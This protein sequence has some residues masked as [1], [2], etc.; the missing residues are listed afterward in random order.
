MG[1]LNDGQL[2]LN[3]RLD[4]LPQPVSELVGSA[5]GGVTG[6]ILGGSA[7]TATGGPTAGAPAPSRK[8]D[9]K[10]ERQQANNWCWAAVTVSVADF[11]EKP[12]SHKQ[13]TRANFHFGQTGCCANPDST[14]CDKPFDP[15]VSLSAVGHFKSSQNSSLTFDQVKEQ[16]N[17]M[18]PIVCF[19]DWGTSV[20][21][22]VVIDGYA[23]SSTGTRYLY[24][25]DPGDGAS[26]AYVEN[27]FKTKYA[28][29]GDWTFTWLTK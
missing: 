2:P 5:L 10:C 6:G 17:A 24:G 15:T 16:V 28:G 14:S 26:F 20:G 29:S 27:D 11:Y 13:C 4:N 19:I 12:S 23:E 1:V 3:L 18:A 21:H 8:R 7:G 25:D 9:F 22:A